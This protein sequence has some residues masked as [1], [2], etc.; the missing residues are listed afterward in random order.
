MN[1]VDRG[2]VSA[3]EFDE[4]TFT[5]SVLDGTLTYGIRNL[6]PAG[7]WYV[8]KLVSLVYVSEGVVAPI[9]ITQEATAIN[10][11]EAKPAAARTIFNAA[12]QQM[13][14]LQRGLNIVDGKKV[15]VK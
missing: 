7:N 12:G 6:A 15:Y 2:W 11:V 13:K 9:I 5:V 14:S 8:A 4:V 3:G 10:E 1:V